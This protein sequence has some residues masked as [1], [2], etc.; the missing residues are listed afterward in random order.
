MPI[1]STKFRKIGRFSRIK[2][3][4][5][6]ATPGGSVRFLTYTALGS[7]TG[8]TDTTPAD[9]RYHLCSIFLPHNMILTGIGYL[10]GS[11]GGTDKVIVSLFDADGKQLA[12][13]TLAGTTVG[14][15]AT[16]QSV[17]F[18]APVQVAGP[19]W[20]LL[21]V[22]MNGTTARLRTIPTALGI[23]QTANA[24]SL[25]ATFGTAGDIS[26]A[27]VPTTFTADVGPVAFTY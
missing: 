23:S 16:M 15:T 18:T 7:L 17:A 27:N 19:G 12:Y 9:G 2:G 5:D 10:I 24:R 8:G 4:V 13:S 14:T 25:S 21:G 26:A 1:L 22:Q 6:L 3:G 20:Y 11:V